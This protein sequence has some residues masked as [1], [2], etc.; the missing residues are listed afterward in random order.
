VLEAATSNKATAVF[1]ILARVIVISWR[2]GFHSVC[3]LGG[4]KLKIKQL[5]LLEWRS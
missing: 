5:A 2:F 1:P 3:T 4:Q